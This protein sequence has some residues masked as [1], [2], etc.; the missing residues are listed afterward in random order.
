MVLNLSRL[1]SRKNKKHTSVRFFNFNKVNFRVL[2][3]KWYSKNMERMPGIEMQKPRYQTVEY[4]VGELLATGERLEQ[5]IEDNGRS[6]RRCV[7]K[8][9]YD[10]GGVVIFA[11]QI[12]REEL[13]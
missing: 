11:E 10:A 8:V 13:G 7:D 1:R 3:S 2:Y 12:S 4:T 5:V 9:S 6:Q